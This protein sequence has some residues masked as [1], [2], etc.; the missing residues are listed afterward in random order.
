MA[1]RKL[2]FFVEGYTEQQFVKKLLIE[3]FGEKQISIKIDEIKGG[4]TIAIKYTTIITPQVSD[5]TQ[6][7]VLIYNCNGDS[8]IKSYILDRRESLIKAGYEKIIGLRDIF[9][10]FTRDDI[11]E[12][13]KGLNYKL[14][15]KELPIIFVLSIMEIESWF[16]AEENH[17]KKIDQKLTSDFISKKFNFNPS[18]DDSQLIDKSA[19]TLKEIY[20]SVGKTYKKE[21]YYIDRTIDSI[22]FAN[23]YFNVQQRINSLENLILEFEE[24]FK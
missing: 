20:K 5:E 2:A 19:E 7:Y 8:K 18:I 12:V 24:I 13:I 4:K 16:L 3:I 9:P 6:Y 17:F 21:K 15:Q 23:I 14:P 11:Q 1:Y 22:D 10:D